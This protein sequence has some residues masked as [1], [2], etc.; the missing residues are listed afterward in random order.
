[1]DVQRALALL[2]LGGEGG[3]LTP[4]A[5][6]R[7]YLATALRTHP[8]K[9]PSDAGA[10]AAFAEL[11]EAHGVAL[12][13]LLARD[14]ARAERAA[15][16]A[17]LDALARALGGEDVR[18]E[19]EALGLHRPP[20]TFGVDLSVRFD[21]RVPPPP[22]PG[23]PPPDVRDALRHAFEDEG[24]TGEGDPAGGYELPPDYEIV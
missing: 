24:L 23:S 2:G 9:R 16:D 14:A 13:S 5:L 10:A 18:A 1:M 7:A 12:A 4:A 20:P 22:R 8:D 3:G 15:A 6:R 11:Q 19:L 21:A 17:Q